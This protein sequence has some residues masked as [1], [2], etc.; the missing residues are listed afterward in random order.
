MHLHLVGGFL[1]SGKTTAIINASRR[2][3]ECGQRVGVITNDQG[4]YLVDTAF[5]RAADIPAVEVTGGCF[6]CNYDDLQDRLG[7]LRGSARPDTVFAESVGSCADIVA[8]VMKPLMELRAPDGPPPSFS[9]FADIRLLRRRHLGM[10]LPFSE[11]VTYLF[12][13]Q[14]EEAGLI[15]INKADSIAPELAE[16]TAILARD[17]FPG[18]PVRLQNSLDPDD[19]AAWL[20]L[21]ESGTLPAYGPPLDIDYAVYGSGERELAWL[22]ERITL[23]VRPG[24]ARNAVMRFIDAAAS[25]FGERGI[26]VGHLKFL[27]TAG[28]ATIKVSI[29]GGDEHGPS[30]CS[31]P[32]TRDTEVDILVNARA[33]TT[34]HVLRD[35]VE[36]ALDRS[37]SEYRISAADAFQPGFPNP[38]HRMT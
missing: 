23:I 31:I 13:K 19:A 16:E 14:I 5:V 6:C 1:G 35:I 15:V 3:M 32:E 33:E 21:I 22:D 18:R 7:Q 12:D 34:P 26:P 38:T 30:S 17:R 11:K 10:P 4:K 29:T 25:E 27:V 20:D 28:G 36:C 9:V 2:I 8:T 37:G 24:D